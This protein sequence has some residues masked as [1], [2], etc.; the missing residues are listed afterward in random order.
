[1]SDK[2]D[3][4][5]KLLKYK[6]IAIQGEIAGPGI[7]KNR[8][9]LKEQELFVFNVIDVKSGRRWRLDEREALCRELGLKHVPV[10]VPPFVLTREY[11]VPVVIN[12]W[13]KGYSTLLRTQKREGV[14]IRAAAETFSVKAINPDYLLEF[15]N[16]TE[17]EE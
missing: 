12:T 6:D 9:Q 16:G 7:Q 15:D 3:L 14:V 4:Q 11:T 13:A 1:M 10:L 8:Y 17:E 5:N 2:Y